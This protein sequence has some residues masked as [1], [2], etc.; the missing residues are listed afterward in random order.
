M[1]RTAVARA[2]RARMDLYILL[3]VWCLTCR[4]VKMGFVLMS[5][6][7]RG[8]LECEMLCDGLVLGSKGAGGKEE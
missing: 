5:F 1:A 4:S 6:E 8:V 2:A 7:L 3:E